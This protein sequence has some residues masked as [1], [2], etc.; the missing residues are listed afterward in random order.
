MNVNVTKTVPV[1]FK[2]VVD[3]YKKVRSGGKAAGI[4][5]ESWEDFDK[6]VERNLYVIW[7]RLASGSY[8]PSA[9]R[10]TEIPKKD[11]SMRKLGIPTLR[12][13]I[14]QCVVKEYME[15][16]IDQ[17]FHRHSY[18]YRPLKS[19]RQ[20]I[21][22]VRKN[23]KEQDWVIDLDIAKFFDEI[24]HELLMKAVER[25]SEENWVR[26]YVSR[27]LKMKIV[28]K[29]GKEY[30]RRGKGTP[31][32]GVISPLLSNI[33]LHYALDKWLELKYPQINFV[34]Y[35]DDMVIH[36]RTKQEA[37][38]ILSAI[39]AR[40][41]EV[42]L[43]INEQKTQIVYCKDYRRTGQHG[44]VQFGFLGFS[45]QPRKSKSKFGEDKSYM[46][47][48]AEIS[49]E[50]QKKIR[51]EIEDAIPWRNTTMELTDIAQ[52]LNS[53][54]RGWINYFGLY[55]KAALRRTMIYV[56]YRIIKWLRNK[57][58]ISGIRKAALKLSVIMHEYP[59]MFY[60]W[61][62]GYCYVIKK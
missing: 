3:A 32:G 45:Y 29:E 58:K 40:L 33:F 35:A 39:K 20:A 31:Q 49:K 9:V 48:T 37:E 60:H 50:N 14:A 61:Q 54:L 19:Q 47:F 41:S 11:G 34:R 44:K 6:D 62:K 46:A 28:D 52:K 16:Q 12:D 26:M 2:M 38:E 15:K 21:E 13:R 36:C 8:H 23:C 24:D 4:D 43:R 25:M 10:E 17:R 22:Q 5:G 27:W 30:D 18:G 51:E 42:K 56:D 55:G 1:T 53:K 59:M 7:N 57:Y